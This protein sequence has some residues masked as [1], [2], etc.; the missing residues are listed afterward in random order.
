MADKTNVPGFED[1]YSYSGASSRA[2]SRASSHHAPNNPNFKTAGSKGN[3]TVISGLES[4]ESSSEGVK[5]NPK[6]KPI[7]GMFYSVSHTPYG[8]FWPLYLGPNKI[9]RS[10]E[11]D[12]ALYEGTVSSNHAIL[13]VLKDEDG[14]YAAIENAEGV[15][16]VKLNGK[17]IRLSRVECNNMDVITVGKN[18]ELLLM[19]IDCEKYGLTPSE[20]FIEERKTKPIRR[21]DDRII[22]KSFKDRLNNPDEDRTRTDDVQATEENGGTKTR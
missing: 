3:E 5:E 13:T 10:S 7:V 9:G 16:G 18:Y 21:H 19:L 17:S 4:D 8:E 6:G 20:S 12:V 2:S 14:L 1:D 15:N 11:N 22:R